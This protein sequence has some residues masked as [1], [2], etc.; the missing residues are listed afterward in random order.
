MKTENS[1]CDGLL[2]APVKRKFRIPVPDP[3]L[4]GPGASYPAA[5]PGF[6]IIPGPARLPGPGAGLP[7]TGPAK[8]NKKKKLGGVRKIDIM[9]VFR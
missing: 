2:N 6:S 7:A 3:R 4:P 5:G 9:I 1:E 8:K